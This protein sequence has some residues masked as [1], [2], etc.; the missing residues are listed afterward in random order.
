[1]MMTWQIVVDQWLETATNILCTAFWA[2]AGAMA[3][4]WL[5]RFFL[6]R[7]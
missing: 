1:M 5:A 4:V 3:I 2:L 7:H 6:G